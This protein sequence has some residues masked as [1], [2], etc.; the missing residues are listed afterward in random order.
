MLATQERS[1]VTETDGR[2][3][4]RHLDDTF[5]F[6]IDPRSHLEPALLLTH[7]VSSY[8]ETYSGYRLPAAVRDVWDT[9]SEDKCA[10][11]SME[12]FATGSLYAP[13]IS[14]DDV[15]QLPWFKVAHSTTGPLSLSAVGEIFDGLNDLLLASH[16][17][18]VDRGLR[19][20]EVT[21]MS[22]D[23]ITAFARVPFMARDHLSAW[24]EFVTRA[25]DEVERRGEDARS[26]ARL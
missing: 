3:A 1:V 2:G 18:V 12:R 22:L 17:R 6:Y 13:Q 23:A 4:F 15:T 19:D 8:A 25:R 5:L 10:P 24:R 14:Y 26:L 9:V 20:A 11:F 7:L 16:Y 21:R